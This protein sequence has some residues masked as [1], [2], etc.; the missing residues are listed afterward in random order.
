MPR[1]KQTAQLKEKTAGGVKLSR[2]RR[3]HSHGTDRQRASAER[4]ASE[5]LLYFPGSNIADGFRALEL[6]LVEPV[7]VY[8]H[9]EEDWFNVEPDEDALLVRLTRMAYRRTLL[10]AA[11]PALRDVWL[12]Q[13]PAAPLERDQ[14]EERINNP[15]DPNV[16]LKDQVA[17]YIDNTDTVTQLAKV[18]IGERY[19]WLLESILYFAPLWLRSPMTFDGSTPAELLR[20]LFAEYPVPTIL[21]KAAHAG[22]DKYLRWFI[23]YGQGASLYKLGQI[24]RGWQVTKRFQHHLARAPKSLSLVYATLFVEMGQT[25]LDARARQWLFDN[26]R[27]TQDLTASWTQEQLDYLRFWRQTAAW[28][29]RHADGMDDYDAWLVLNWAAHTF[30][31][32][33]FSW[34][35]RSLPASVRHAEA[36]MGENRS[37]GSLWRNHGVDWQRDDIWS[38][39]EICSSAALREEGNAMRHCVA[40][41][42]QICA[43][44]WAAVFSLRRRGVRML[45]IDIDLRT[46]RVREMKRFGNGAATEAEIAIVDEWMAAHPDFFRVEGHIA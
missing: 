21:D 13:M 32:D 16:P 43:K 22:S 6:G 7:D 31:V 44:G 40:A 5:Q 30:Q 27:F 20:H 18:C 9:W 34:A 10:H 41:Y 35:G 24:S 15:W 17:A 39:R 4:A 45:T 23:C 14:L 37:T 29:Q 26:P 19:A 46:R 36:W 42:D 11:P 33:G 38:V 8:L 12:D 3:W 2:R 25:G 28:L 1:R